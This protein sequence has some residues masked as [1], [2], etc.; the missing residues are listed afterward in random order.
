MLGC[1]LA[2]L[3]VQ[4]SE[5]LLKDPLITV[6][7]FDAFV[8]AQ[9]DDVPWEL[10]AGHIMAMTNPT[11]V[12]EKIVSNL[13]VQLKLAM[14]ALDCHTYFGRIRI[15]RSEDWRG[16]DKLKSD[17]V[18]RCG[19]LGTRNFITD[20]QIVVEVLS[21]STMDMD[22]GEKLRFYKTL[23]TLR[24]IALVYQDQMRVEHY[25]KTDEGWPLE[26]LPLPDDVL[27]FEAV[28]FE[29]GL[30]RIYF[31]AEPAARRPDAAS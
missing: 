19:P 28:R 22:R 3:T 14:D 20:P 6:A 23:P 1:P 4:M 15:Q 11:E 25:R 26:V 12:H 21:P 5:A 13:G 29:I 31:G 24:H 30:G 8:D 27:C 17:I 2:E 10:V 18:A 9:D 16:H 7:A